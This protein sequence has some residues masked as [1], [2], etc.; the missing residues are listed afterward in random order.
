ML[1]LVR[2]KT[3]GL[4]VP[5]L[6]SLL[7]LGIA[8]GETLGNLLPNP[9]FEEISDSGRPEGWTEFHPWG[10]GATV[11]VDETVAHSGSRSVK[12][13]CPSDT[14]RGTVGLFLPVEPG[15]TYQFQGWLKTEGLI[16]LYTNKG[17][18]ARFSLLENKEDPSAKYTLYAH[19]TGATD[20]ELV[21]TAFVVPPGI[22]WIRLDLFML[23]QQGTAWWDD[24]EFFLR[25]EANLLPNSSFE[26][27][28]EGVLLRW[29]RDNWG[30]KGQ[31]SIDDSTAKEGKVSVKLHA[32]SGD[33][34]AAVNHRMFVIPGATYRFSAWVKTE[35]VV[36]GDLPDKGPLARIL[37]Y[38]DDK[39]TSGQHTILVHAPKNQEWT[40]V[41]HEFT[42]PE[43]MYS[44]RID[45][46]MFFQ[47]GTV[48]WDD[49]ELAFISL[50]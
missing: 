26:L 38:E 27:I 6:I 11:I 5:L 7:C 41:S 44:M 14:D 2:N 50:P 36:G 3:F 39:A 40:Y 18:V 12:I 37:F 29:G 16:G 34:R 35:G 8:Q 48:W 49:V 17:P 24:V 15:Q 30:T 32:P 21:E 19:G 23:F 42:V 25:D 45:L 22:N 4:A 31:V 1:N 13:H 33:D 9:S 28:H 10:T 43:G 46:F 47:P 20:W